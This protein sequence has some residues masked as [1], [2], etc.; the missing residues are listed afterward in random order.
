[1]VDNIKKKSVS[2]FGVTGSVG[3]STQELIK[4]NTKNF[5]VDTI[6]SNDN[7]EELIEAAILLSPKLVIINNNEKFLELKNGLKEYNFEI[8][9]GSNSIVEASKRNVHVLVAAITGF[10]GLNSTISSIGHANIIAIA[11][12]ESIV[13]A[14]PI[15]L[16][17]IKTSFTKIIPIDSEHN[18]LY[19]ILINTNIN[20]VSKIIITGSGG[21]FRGYSYEQLNLVTPERAVSHP[22][23]SMGKKISVDSATLMN[24][25]LEL[26][27]AV[28]LFDINQDK[29]EIIIHPESVIHGIVEYSDGSMTAGLSS[30]DMKNPISYAL[31][32]PNKVYAN[33][34]K[35]NLT[36]IK[37]L[38]FEKVDS[39][40]FKT[41]AISREAILSGHSFVIALNAINEIAVEYFLNE[42]INFNS[43][44][45][46]IEESL[47]R[48]KNHNIVTIQDVLMVD[49]EARNI[50]NGIISIGKFK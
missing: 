38:N 4:L 13:C 1:M 42:V 44:I 32:Y 33:I 31:N 11:N 43:I 26:I 24:K 22:I 46:V 12:K 39:N 9:S 3:K 47:D 49:K 29:I 37:S 41:V 15:L 36:S 6:V 35:L 25:G 28:Y 27:E 19:Q 40:V 30:P 8:A 48:I 20:N 23:W 14:G 2:I 18:T 10:A 7:V 17:K 21:P 34:K 45:S 16:D 5:E 50:A